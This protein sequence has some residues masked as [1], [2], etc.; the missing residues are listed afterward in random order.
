MYSL[1][2]PVCDQRGAAL[3]Y[4]AQDPA[5][6]LADEELLLA[7]HRVRVARESLEVSVPGPERAQQGKQRRAP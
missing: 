7:E 3:G 2:E 1:P 6:R 4:L 5:D